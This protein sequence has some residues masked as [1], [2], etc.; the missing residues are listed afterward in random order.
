VTTSATSTTTSRM[1]LRTSARPRRV[2]RTGLPPAAGR[3]PAVGRTPAAGRPPAAGRTP[4]AGRLPAADGPPA[5][6]GAPAAGCTESGFGSW[7][8]G[9]GPTAARRGRGI[10][11]CWQ[12]APEPDRRAGRRFVGRAPA[13]GSTAIAA[14]A[15]TSSTAGAGA[16]GRAGTSLSVTTRT[17]GETN[18][19]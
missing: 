15:N 11:G 18:T 7:R 13:P 4:A 2:S 12:R 5:A 19:D 6:G 17:P 1:A 14:S 16:S 8:A 10:R 9:S 3:P